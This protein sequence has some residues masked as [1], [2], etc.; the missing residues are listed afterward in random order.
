MNPELELIATEEIERIQMYLTRMS[1]KTQILVPIMGRHE[2]A[3]NRYIHT[4]EVANSARMLLANIAIELN[5][6]F[7]SEGKPKITT[8]DLDYQSALRQVCLLHDIGHP[9][10]GHDGATFLDK[11]F[12]SRGLEEGFDDNNNNLVIIDSR[13]IELR[14]YVKVNI[15]KYPEKLY[16]E[17]KKY[18]EMLK[19]YVLEDIEH[20]KKLGINIPK[21]NLKNVKGFVCQIMDEADRNTYTCTDLSDFF[22]LSKTKPTEEELNNAIIQINVKNLNK[23][24]KKQNREITQEELNNVNQLSVVQKIIVKELSSLQEKGVSEIQNYFENKMKL[25]NKNFRIKTDSELFEDNKFFIT[26]K[27]E[28]IQQ[29]RELFSDITYEMFIRPIRKQPFH[30]NNMQLLELLV[31]RTYEEQF[32][33]STRYS[34]K[35]KSALDNNDTEGYLKAV[36]DMVGELTDWYVIRKGNELTEG[37]DQTIEIMNMDSKKLRSSKPKN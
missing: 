3:R 1:E 12:K 28:T 19:K 15:I 14:D 18:E 31:N 33:E 21:D 20:L 26:Y 29:M 9:P 34:K 35:M 13:N 24:A 6:K 32:T 16:S 10:F 30:L 36:R 11:Y 22:N 8:D 2:V 4:Q 37:L 5:K 25:F 27:D 7:E 23:K 17:Q